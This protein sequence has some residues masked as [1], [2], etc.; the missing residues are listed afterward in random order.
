MLRKQIREKFD[1]SDLTPSKRCFQVDV[2]L[3]GVIN[4]WKTVEI[5]GIRYGKTLAEKKN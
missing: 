4:Y 3:S 1:I 2:I 5:K